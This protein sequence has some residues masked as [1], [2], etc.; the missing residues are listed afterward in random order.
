MF[1]IVAIRVKLKIAQGNIGCNIYST[2]TLLI[3]RQYSET[4]FI[5][6]TIILRWRSAAFRNLQHFGVNPIRVKRHSYEFRVSLCHCAPV[7]ISY[8]LNGPPVTFAIMKIR[9]YFTPTL[10]RTKSLLSQRY[11]LVP[12]NWEYHERGSTRK[13]T[14]WEGS[15][16]RDVNTL[17]W[18]R[19][20]LR[21]DSYHWKLVGGNTL[22]FAVIRGKQNLVWP[23]VKLLC[24]PCFHGVTFPTDSDVTCYNWSGHDSRDISLSLR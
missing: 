3:C 21:Y 7:F 16:K 15:F 14:V 20:I 24:L 12:G 5:R 18:W 11:L 1:A 22:S 6:N 4:S 19:F 10:R 23:S 13:F 17:Y 9:C 8:K 2:R